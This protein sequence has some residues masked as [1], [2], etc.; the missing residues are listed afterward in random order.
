MFPNIAQGFFEKLTQ[1]SL[2]LDAQ[3]L[4]LNRIEGTG[5]DFKRFKAGK[6][7]LECMAVDFI[8]KVVN[9]QL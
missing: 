6:V 8:E 1:F 9:W 3:V 4:F 2:L 5:F 7:S